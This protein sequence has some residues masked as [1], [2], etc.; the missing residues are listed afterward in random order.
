VTPQEILAEVVEQ[1]R[2]IWRF[3]WW[4][5][6]VTWLFALAGW[7]YVSSL[8]ESYQASAR[9][10]VDTGS[11]LR[12]LMQGLTAQQNTMSAVQLVT[13]AVLTRPNL[14]AVARQ[15]GLDL[16]TRTPEQ[17]EALVTG[18]QTRIRVS[19]GDDSVF[20]I[21]FEDESRDMARE[22]VAGVLDMFV[23]DVLGAQG[24]DA[25]MS[26]RAL[27][28]EIEEHE[29]RLRDAEETLAEFKKSNLGY[30]PGESGD[31]Y[32]R[33][34]TA[35]GEVARVQERLRQLGQRREELLR[36][37]EGEE[38]V[39]GIMPS[40]GGQVLTNCS[41]SSQ[42]AA[43]EAQLSALLVDYTEKYPR[44]VAL[45]ENIAAL[46]Q[47]CLDESAAAT[48]AGLSTRTLGSSESLDTNPVYQNLRIQLSNTE[49]ELVE[50]R[51]ELR[52]HEAAVADLRRDVDKI[53][54]VETELKQ[55]NR[56][57]TVVQSRH[58][59]LLRRWEDLQAKQRLDPVT[60]NNQFRR[61]EPP[62]ALA[63]PVG[64]DRALFLSMVFV[65]ATVAGGGV[66]FGL[67]RLRPVCFSRR[68]VQR[69]TG[70]PVL[71]S[72]SLLLS[73]S[74][75]RRRDLAALAWVSSYALLILCSTLAIVFA[76]PGAEL[77]RRLLGG[78][79]A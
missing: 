19:G 51:E 72:I 58:Q 20:R 31:Y 36:Q 55:L 27:A 75:A 17:F 5:A 24:D 47:R 37:I 42:L 59:E 70:I 53:G 46:Q 68:A 77:F 65:F 67:N 54:Q 52:T 41:Q 28:G 49:V 60:D 57:Y 40:T 11:L 76:T 44:V 78:G 2:G 9:V 22:V 33:L 45:K 32:N 12:P 3:R 25:A 62:F 66:A 48:A 23:E 35:L 7:M 63:D 39:F 38:P 4:A 21:Q 34:Q 64:P 56:D 18:L 13:T 73:G 43:M 30:M 8:P 14:E 6:G 69:V 1:L 61:I 29:R 16:R 15:A 74:A 79:E 50:L 10:Y 71:G 26:E